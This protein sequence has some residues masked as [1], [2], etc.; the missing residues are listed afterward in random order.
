MLQ[1]AS[2]LSPLPWRVAAVINSGLLFLLDLGLIPQ[3]GAHRL[4]ASKLSGPETAA[5][6]ERANYR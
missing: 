3:S 6:S 5:T 4:R 1:P 2:I